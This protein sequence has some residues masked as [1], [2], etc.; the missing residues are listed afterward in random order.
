MHPKRSHARHSRVPHQPHP[1]FLYTFSTLLSLLIPLA[2][3]AHQLLASRLFLPFLL[4]V[5]VWF[6]MNMQSNACLTFL[7]LG[8]VECS[9]LLLDGTLFILLLVLFLASFFILS[10]FRMHCIQCDLTRNRVLSAGRSSSTSLFFCIAHSA[11]HITSS[12]SFA[13]TCS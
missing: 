6:S 9:Y 13:C 3:L 5:C 2:S 1:P 8:L 4:F 12:P 11:S 7:R 10:F